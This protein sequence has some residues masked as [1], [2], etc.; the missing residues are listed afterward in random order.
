HKS[1]GYGNVDNISLEACYVN[2]KGLSHIQ[3]YNYNKMDISLLKVSITRLIYLISNNII[4]LHYFILN[5]IGFSILIWSILFWL[6]LCQL[7]LLTSWTLYTKT[8]KIE[9]PVQTLEVITTDTK[10]LN[11]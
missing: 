5:N 2:L 7:F 6:A 10:I 3:Y 1:R 8:I 9:Q 4:I 11:Y